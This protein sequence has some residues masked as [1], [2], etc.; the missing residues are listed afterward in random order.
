MLYLCNLI[1]NNM[2]M[3]EETKSYAMPLGKAIQKV[4]N[5]EKL[6]KSI[7]AKLKLLD[8]LMYEKMLRF[9]N[10]M[11][12]A[13]EHDLIYLERIIDKEIERYSQIGVKAVITDLNTNTDGNG[14]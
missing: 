11:V 5:M 4:K 2:E 12:E 1:L 14:Y 13:S 7:E 8:V 10:I 6:E 3:S 9:S